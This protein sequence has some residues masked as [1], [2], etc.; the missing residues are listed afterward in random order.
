MYIIEI[1]FNWLFAKSKV[2]YVSV[3]FYHR[4]LPKV[5]ITSHKKRIKK[6]FFFQCRLLLLVL[7]IIF[8]FLSILHSGCWWMCA[9]F[10]LWEMDETLFHY[11][12]YV[13]SIID[14]MIW[15]KKQACIA[16]KDHSE[17]ANVKI[18]KKKTNKKKV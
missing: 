18:R 3:F 6:S 4:K 10:R 11:L 16:I 1:H 9:E 7:F 8:C 5:S 15:M 12:Y 17:I 14:L 13:E 2:P